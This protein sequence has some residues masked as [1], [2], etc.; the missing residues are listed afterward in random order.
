[1]VD[2]SQRALLYYLFS[3]SNFMAALG[4]GMILGKGIGAINIPMLRSGSLL[5]FFVGTVFGLGF[6]QLTPKKFS[7]ILAR[8]FS[9]SGG[10]TSLMLCGI[11]S[12]YAITEKISGNAAV[13]FF[14]LLSL[15]FGF[16]FY[17]RVLRASAAAGQ[18]QSIAWVELGY[19]SGIISGLVLW[20]FLGVNINMIAALIVD[21]ILQ[22][23][24]GT[25]DLYVYRKQALLHQP[26]Q[27]NASQSHI[28][29]KCNQKIW[30]WRLAT[31]VMFLTVGVQVI[32]FNLAHKVS[33]YFS[34]YILAV[35]YLGAAVSAI[36]FKRL[37]MQLEWN[38]LKTKS[39]G[40]AIILFGRS[41]NKKKM[42]FL[43]GSIVSGLSVIAVLVSIFHWQWGIHTPQALSIKEFFLLVFVFISTFFY[44]ILE[45]AI[46]DRIGIEEKYSSNKGMILHTYGIMSIAAVASLWILQI[47]QSSIFGL[48]STLSICFSLTIL[49][50]QKRKS[51]ISYS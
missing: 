2:N 24:A 29:I 30:V 6:L 39:N 1:M 49:S 12:S 22:L 37:N 50:V 46:L 14:F 43:F 41:E 8:W 15:R 34:P 36:F 28:N 47:T 17:S 23:G 25:L 4:G 16:W 35:F 26:K 9:I 21:S 45:L 33:D 32:I 3:I 38:S 5:A 42:S 40:Y 10:I 18:K 19:Y 11:F 44:G 7:T 27:I 48:F 13:I 31:A 51:T 20:I